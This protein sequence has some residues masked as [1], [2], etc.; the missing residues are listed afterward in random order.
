MKRVLAFVVVVCAGTLGAMYAMGP[1]ETRDLL[2]FEL[3]E[4]GFGAVRQRMGADDADAAQKRAAAEKAAAEKDASSVK[5][6]SSAADEDATAGKDASAKE[7]AEAPAAPAS[8]IDALA[9]VVDDFLSQQGEVW[10]VYV[11]D[12]ATGEALN[13]YDQPMEAASLIK[14]FVMES[15]YAHRDELIRYDSAYT[16]DAQASAARL[17][18]LLAAMVSDSDNEAFNT[19]VRMHSPSR[20]FKEGAR[21]IN[22]YLPYAET[23]VNHSLLPSETKITGISN[24][25]NQTSVADC[26]AL[27]AAIADS[28]C[29]SAEASAAMRALLAAQ[30]W[31]DKIPAGLPEGTL[32]ANK[33]GENDK[34]QHDVAIISGPDRD[35]ILCVMVEN[36]DA[37]ASGAIA[38]LSSRVYSALETAQ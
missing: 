8:R 23:V 5:E 32:C 14:L 24:D 22:A 6:A 37:S 17:D 36:A 16:G 19:L 2:P 31:R 10:S 11:R 1:E 35:Y 18:M 4:E 26:G 25:V 33:T 3:V 34:V 15:A 9:A 28:R 12:L 7:A 27:L 21:A 20:D 13:R 30:S 29:V 38:E